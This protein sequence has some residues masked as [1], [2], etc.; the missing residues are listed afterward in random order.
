MWVSFLMVVVVDPFSNRIY[1]ANLGSSSVSVLDGVTNKGIVTIEN[2]ST[3]INLALDL[4][5]SYLYAS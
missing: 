5:D 3:P 2:V 4:E 1:V